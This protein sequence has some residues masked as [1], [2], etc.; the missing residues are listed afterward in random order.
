M[1]ASV[2]VS[3]LRGHRDSVVSLDIPSEPPDHLVLSCSDDNTAR[4]W[5]VRTHTSCRR[6]HDTTFDSQDG[7]TMGAARFRPGHPHQ[8]YVAR[9]GALYAFDLRRSDRV[10]LNVSSGV[11]GF[12]GASSA[13]GEIDRFAFDSSGGTMAV[14]LES[15]SVLVCEW[16][17]E[18]QGEGAG[19]GWAVKRELTGEHGNICG[20]A[21]FRAGCARDLVTG[22]YDC[23][24]CRWDASSGKCRMRLDM[25][26]VHSELETSAGAKQ[27]VNPPFVEDLACSHDGSKMAVAL[28]DGNIVLYGFTG[29][30]LWPSPHSGSITHLSPLSCVT[31]LPASHTHLF[32][33]S[34]DRQLTLW[35]AK[36]SLATSTSSRR[37]VA[38]QCGCHPLVQHEMGHKGNCIVAVAG[39][40]R[41]R[42]IVGDVSSEIKLVDFT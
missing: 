25:N 11:E 34:N 12:D 42:A 14:P 41:G 32:S 33:L 29:D 31:F 37:S 30:R 38:S 36:R 10:L 19:G 21:V 13:I 26:K 24:V 6:L 3:A 5:D 9:G 7:S 40:G 23:R 27:L 39:E 18:G 8:I 20:S 4:L 22:G 1:T 28:G 2:S 16:E 17:G 15:G 35:E